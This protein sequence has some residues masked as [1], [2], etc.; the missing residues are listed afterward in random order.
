MDVAGVARM[1]AMRVGMIVHDTQ[2]S[3]P[4]TVRTLHPSRPPVS[5]YHIYMKP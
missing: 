2:A 1:E 3:I 5:T 4:M